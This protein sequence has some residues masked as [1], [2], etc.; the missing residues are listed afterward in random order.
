LFDEIPYNIELKWQ[1]SADSVLFF[2][3]PRQLL[4]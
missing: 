1:G 4:S 2:S 3:L